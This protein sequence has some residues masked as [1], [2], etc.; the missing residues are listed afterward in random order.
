[1]PSKFRLRRIF[2]PLVIKIAQGLSKLKVKPNHASFMMLA[3]SIISFIMIVVLNNLILFGVFVFITGIFDGVDGAIARLTNN[4]TKFGGFLDSTLDRISEIII[5]IGL[6]IGGAKFFSL[7]S[8]IFEVLILITF[9]SSLFISYLRSRAATEIKADFDV[10]LFA[11]SERL[12]ALFLI[13]VIPFAI[14]FTYGFI[15]LSI[16]I[17]ATAIFRFLKYKHYFEI[18]QLNQASINS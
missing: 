3:F 4:S 5:Y 2:R 7:N 15:L 6:Y 12:F 16:G 17:V 18:E 10:G 13:S 14:V 8:T 9:F 11:R 1:M